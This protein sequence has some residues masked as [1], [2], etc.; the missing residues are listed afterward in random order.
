MAPGVA[1]S[2]VSATATGTTVSRR[3]I[4]VAGDLALIAGTIFATLA[5]QRHFSRISAAIDIVD[6]EPPAASSSTTNP[7]TVISTRWREVVLGTYDR[8]GRDRILATAAG[9]VFYGL[10]AIFPAVTALVS[11]YGLFADPVDDFRE[12]GEARSDAA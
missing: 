4:F 7:L 9:V 5:I 10:L 1:C 8:I 3:P 2:I 6:G 11:S 12:P